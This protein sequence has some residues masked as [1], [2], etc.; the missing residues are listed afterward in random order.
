MRLDPEERKFTFAE[1]FT[2]FRVRN[3]VYES[4][5]P[6]EGY[7][8]GVRWSDFFRWEA[9]QSVNITVFDT[10]GRIIWNDR[11]GQYGSLNVTASTIACFPFPV[12][13]TGQRQNIVT[14]LDSIVPAGALVFLYTAI[15]N[16]SLDLNVQEWAMDSVSSGGRNIFNVL[17]SEGAGL[18]RSLEQQMVPYL[19][20]YRK[21]EGV[22]YEEKASSINDVII[23]E[24]AIRGFWDE[25]RYKSPIVGPSKNWESAFWGYTLGNEN[26]TLFLSL[27]GLD[28]EGNESIIMDEVRA[29][30]INLSDIDAAEFPYLQF[31]L[32]AKDEAETTAPQLDF[33]R[34]WYQGVPDLAISPSV[35][36]RLEHDSIQQGQEFSLNVAIENVSRYDSDSLLVKFV[37][38]GDNNNE[39]SFYYR[40]GPLEKN[41][42]LIASLN[43]ESKRLAG[44]QKL[45]MEV[46]PGMD[47]LEQYSFNNFFIDQFFVEKDKHN[48]ILDVTFD[49]IHIVDGDLVSSKPEIVIR[50]KDENPYLS[51]LDTNSIRVFINHPEGNTYPVVIDGGN[52]VFYPAS[53]AGNNLAQ[54]EYRPSFEESGIYELVVRAR[55]A[56][57]NAAGGLD[58]KISFEV[59]TERLISNVLNYPNPFST[60]THFVYTL[61]GD[62]PPAE[63]KIQI[64]TV[65]GRVVREITDDEIGPLR[66]GT[67]RTDFTWDG[68][69]DY[70]GQLANGVYLYKIYAKD[71]DGKDF[72]SYDNGTSRYFKNGIGK[73]VILR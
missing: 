35:L 10:L 4:S 64:M 33:W 28:A 51:L 44:L 48:P 71:V 66:V 18:I 68:R 21:G 55:D 62:T 45:L 46:N 6:P 58:Y 32:Y 39:S 16:P 25:G 40:Y 63:F 56:T 52:A 3:K 8:N 27:I 72:E 47:Q 22:L 20:C 41:D 53:S 5:F 49:G 70:G 38:S 7:I 14:F 23:F 42:T 15:R 54:L 11:P 69:D 13:N 2:D 73:L 12:E 34:V 31:Q 1:D 50:L 30:E 36:Y 37:L 65:S 43:L 61:T 19:I 59:I 60:S 26:D 29:T 57:G 67:H 24:Y 17:E 9:S